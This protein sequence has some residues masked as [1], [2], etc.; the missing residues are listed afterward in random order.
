MNWVK[1]Q[2]R[3]SQASWKIMANEVMVMPTK[4]GDE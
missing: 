2:L 4:L 1:D 3:A